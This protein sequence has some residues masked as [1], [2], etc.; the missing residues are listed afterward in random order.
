MTLFIGQSTYKSLNGRLDIYLMLWLANLNLPTASSFPDDVFCAPHS[1][2]FSQ[3]CF[4]SDRL[5]ALDQ[6]I[7]I[8]LLRILKLTRKV[9]SMTSSTGPGGTAKPPGPQEGTQMR[10][11]NQLKAVLFSAV[12]CAVKSSDTSVPSAVDDATKVSTASEQDRFSVQEFSIE[13]SSFCGWKRSPDL[14]KNACLAP[15]LHPPAETQDPKL[16]S[17]AKQTNDGVF[18]FMGS[19]LKNWR[20]MLS[21]KEHRKSGVCIYNRAITELKIKTTLSNH[22]V[23]MIFAS[24]FICKDFS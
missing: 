15:C 8:Y 14:P 22:Y 2:H 1:Q 7:R 17:K 16:K 11:E 21:S 10:T 18:A 3:P 24:V 9:Q 13:C 12:C 23:C 6:V 19:S 4:N 20:R 5:W